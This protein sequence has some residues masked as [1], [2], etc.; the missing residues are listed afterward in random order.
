MWLV[1]CAVAVCC[2]PSVIVGQCLWKYMLCK[3][4]VVMCYASCVVVMSRVMN[5]Y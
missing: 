5:S 4:L 1:Y 3:D 2:M